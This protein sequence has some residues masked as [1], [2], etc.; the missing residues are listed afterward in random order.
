MQEHLCKRHE[1]DM[2]A[3]AYQ[4][5][6]MDCI[7]LRLSMF[8]A[9]FDLISCVCAPSQLGS[10]MFNFFLSAR[11]CR[12]PLWDLKQSAASCWLSEEYC[13]LQGPGPSSTGLKRTFSID[14]YQHDFQH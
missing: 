5:K 12:T 4:V 6:S 10:A 7:K 9:A 8:Y 14:W 13:A 11:V 3:D 1:H 2:S